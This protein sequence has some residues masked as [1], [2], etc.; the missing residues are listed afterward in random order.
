MTNAKIE[1]KK[2]KLKFDFIQDGYIEED[3]YLKLR[4][5]FNDRNQISTDQVNLLK[6]NPSFFRRWM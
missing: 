1:I 2:K 6:L 3:R 4:I 5:N